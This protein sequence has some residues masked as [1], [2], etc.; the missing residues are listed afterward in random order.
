MPQEIKTGDVL[1]IE[2]NTEISKMVQKAQRY[3][4]VLRRMIPFLKS[5]NYHGIRLSHVLISMDKG[6][7]IHAAGGKA[8]I[9]TTLDE[10]ISQGLRY[11]V[12]RKKDF[13]QNNDIKTF[14]DLPSYYQ[15]FVRQLNNSFIG[16]ITPEEFYY[17]AF[18]V[19]HLEMK[20]E[21]GKK[22]ALNHLKRLINWK[23]KDASYCSK[24]VAD[25]LRRTKDIKFKPWGVIF[26]AYLELKLCEDERWED[27][28][29]QYAIIIND[30]SL[31]TNL[32]TSANAAKQVQIKIQEESSRIQLNTQKVLALYENSIDV[33]KTVTVLNSLHSQW[34]MLEKVLSKAYKSVLDKRWND[35]DI[36]KEIIRLNKKALA[37]MKRL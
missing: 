9:Y 28:T 21:L 37:K 23:V 5:Y 7:F 35:I 20:Y 31:Y 27:V 26:P 34:T 2:G 19:K 33:S 4:I 14:D 32:I 29:C 10:Y 36:G 25:L 13:M 6:M 11:R 22:Y 30:K 18:H 17:Y 3:L 16:P 8:I 24:F 15:R 1:F 12:Y